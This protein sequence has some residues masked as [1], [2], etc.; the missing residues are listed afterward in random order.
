[1]GSS[2][3][4]ART[5]VACIGRQIHNHCAAREARC[6]WFNT[7]FT[8][9]LLFANTAL[10]DNLG[11]CFYD[12]QMIRF[13]KAKSLS[14]SDTAGTREPWGEIKGFPAQG[15]WGCQHRFLGFPIRHSLLWSYSAWKKKAGPCPI[16]EWGQEA[17]GCHQTQGKSQRPTP[18]SF[19]LEVPVVKH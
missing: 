15:W 9:I 18:T 3:T 12:L 13:R 4:R 8:W 19:L 17:R 16:W 7:I 6:S 10:G 2:Q 14:W 5:R 1:M 11:R